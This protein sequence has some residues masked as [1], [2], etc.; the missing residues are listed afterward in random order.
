M[1][2]KEK[3]ESTIALIKV[4]FFTSEAINSAIEAITSEAMDG[5]AILISR[6]YFLP[7]IL[8]DP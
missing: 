8:K 3:F 2:L 7:W 4:F 5:H 6:E 1:F